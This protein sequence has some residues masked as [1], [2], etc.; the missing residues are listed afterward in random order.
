MNEAKARRDLV[1]T[2]MALS[3]D[4]ICKDE[5][6]TM[7]SGHHE[8]QFQM[9][10]ATVYT[11]SEL[12]A[13]YTT[14][15]AEDLRHFSKHAKRATISVDDVKLCAR[16]STM[17]SKAMESYC[18]GLRSEKSTNKGKQRS[19]GNNKSSPMRE[20]SNASANNGKN[21]KRKST[22]DKDKRKK[23]KK[24][25]KVVDSSSDSGSSSDALDQAS[26]QEFELN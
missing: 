11:L 14:T 7:N 10:Q 5:L 2:R 8:K 26:E 13:E 4:A 18:D 1:R 9:G 22:Q 25:N 3:V 6:Q 16:K 19:R 20:N 24:A 15:F 23:S 17:L 21:Q 12:L